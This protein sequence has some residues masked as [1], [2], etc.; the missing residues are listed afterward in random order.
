MTL[1]ARAAPDEGR[2]TRVLGR[3]YGGVPDPRTVELLAGRL[4]V[5]RPGPVR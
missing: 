1:F 4:S 2:F 5:P 3:F